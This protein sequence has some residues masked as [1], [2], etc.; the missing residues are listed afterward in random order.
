MSPKELQKELREI[1][2][3]SRGSRGELIKRYDKEVQGVEPEKDQ[4]GKSSSSVRPPTSN[5]SENPMMVM[6][7]ESTGNKYMRVVDR[8]GL[9]GAGGN[10]GLVKDMHQELKSWGHPG[11]ARNALILKSDGER[12]IVAVR[13]ALARCHGGRITLEKPPRGEHQ[14]NGVAEEAG[15]TIRDH[16]RVMKLDL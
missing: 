3:S 11:G 2:K 9:G 8:K 6:V 5:T 1:G 10:S 12:A 7:D 14:A 16:A 15:R 13:E 4:E